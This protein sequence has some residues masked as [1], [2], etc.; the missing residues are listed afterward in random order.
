MQ[1]ICCQL[2]IVWEDKIANHA[3]VIGL[4]EST[5]VRPGD[6]IILPE[7]F[8]VGFSNNIAVIAEDQNA[9][10][11]T[12]I[13]SLAQKYKAY[14]LAGIVTRGSDKRGRNQAVV[15]DPQGRELARYDKLHP[16]TLSGESDLFTPG[17]GIVTFP[18]H[19]FNASVFICYDLRFP[20][21]FRAAVCQGAQLMIV[22]ANWPKVRQRH[23]ATLLQ[24]RALEN[25]AYVVGVNRCGSDPNHDYL[26]QSTIIDPEGKILACADH[27]QQIIKATLDHQALSE[28]RQ[29]FPFLDDIRK[30]FLPAKKT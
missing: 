19:Q 5:D 12:F 13:K 24:A 17:S 11:L 21:I 20:E 7:M 27:T 4:L 23:W 9:T 18:W 8:D 26:G 30:D 10:T 29:T 16:F 6:L 2:D 14:V 3:K 22:I 25:Q 28:Y 15:I 1:I